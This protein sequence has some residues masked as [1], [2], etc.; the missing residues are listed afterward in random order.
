MPE[1]IEE[2]VYV[3]PE[4]SEEAGI[5]RSITKEQRDKIDESDFAWPDAPGGPKYPINSQSHLDAAAKLIGRAPEDE[6]GKIKTNAIRIAKKHGFTLP[7]SWTEGDDNNKD[8][9]SKSDRAVA[10]EVAQVSMPDHALLYAPI[11]RIDSTKWEVEGV[12]TSESPDSF[13]T[14]F[15]YEASKRAFEAWASKYANIREMH[16]R[17]AVAK[18]I[19]Y[20]FDDA[21]KQIFVRGRV[22]RGAPDTWAKVQEDILCGFSIGASNCKW[23]S[24]ERNGKTYPYCTRYDLVELSLVDRPSNADCNIAVARADGLTDVVDVTEPEPEQPATPVAV[25]VAPTEERAGAR[26]SSDTQSGMHA[27]RDGAIMN[28]MALMSLCTCPECQA[29]IDAIDPDHDGDIDLPGADTT[30]DPD[31]DADE[32]AE[33]VASRVMDKVIS[34]L[35][36]P[37]MRM[38]TIAG[39]FARIQTP[40]INLTPLQQSIDALTTRLADVAT[41]SNLDEV[42]SLLSEVEGQVKRIAEQPATGGPVLNAAVIDKRFATQ[43]AY[44]QAS[45]D[46]EQRVLERLASQGKLNTH[47]LQTAAAATRLKRM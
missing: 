8:S 4:G 21:S 5:Q 23:D 6:Q 24:V 16:D 13:G 46:D 28:A 40:E 1:T 30:L 26:L 11:T 35:D 39:Q 25:V 7:D 32:L 43:S 17:K 33:R 9:D 31:Q 42:R 36:A 10:Q 19:E 34:R 44:P 22:S 27:A 15:G 3:Y 14:I 37:V 12:A 45:E 2:V 41:T 29:M 20:R 38:H 47:E 18:G